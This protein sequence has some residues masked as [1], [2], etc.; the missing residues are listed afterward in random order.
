[1]TIN[2]QIEKD[3]NSRNK[4]I[5]SMFH[6]IDNVLTENRQ[7]DLEFEMLL[8]Q[9]NDNNFYINNNNI[10]INDDN[11][12]VMSPLCD[13]KDNHSIGNTIS[14]AQWNGIYNAYLNY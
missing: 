9:R 3:A 7:L 14:T 6:S 5:N 12:I 13:S 1:M 11:E 10:D 4:E 2:N 8:K